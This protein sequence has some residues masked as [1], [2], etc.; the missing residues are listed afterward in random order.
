[1]VNFKL[2][3]EIELFRQE[4]RAFLAEHLTEAVIAT[5]ETT[6]TL[7]DEGFARALGDRGWIGSAKDRGVETDS[8]GWL[9]QAV[10][11]EEFGRAHAPVDWAYTTV[12]AAR[13]IR[14]SG[15]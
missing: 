3:D 1:M 15:T 9:R 7:Y 4:V 2:P 11:V 10:L 14:R 13:S 8:L 5:M 12:L 6:G